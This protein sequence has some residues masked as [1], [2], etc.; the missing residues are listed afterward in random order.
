MENFRIR[1]IQIQIFSVK[2]LTYF[3]L[4]C[5]LKGNLKLVLLAGAGAAAAAATVVP[6]LLVALAGTGVNGESLCCIITWCVV[7]GYCGDWC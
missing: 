1:K 2:E 3:F 4:E 7:R 6:G 5:F